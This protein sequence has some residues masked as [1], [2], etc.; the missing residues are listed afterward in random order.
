MQEEERELFTEEEVREAG[1]KIKRRKAP[2]TY[3]IPQDIIKLVVDRF[4]RDC[5]NASNNALKQGK[6]RMILKEARLA[7]VEKPKKD[8]SVIKAYR[9]LCVINTAG[10]FLEHM[11]CY[12][13]HTDGD[14]RA[15]GPIRRTIWVPPR[16]V[17]RGRHEEDG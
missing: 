9:P 14:R 12:R 1:A 7:L 5:R 15:R 11:L 10:K 16:K 2:G 6:I 8:D 17:N 4:P 3:K 13:I